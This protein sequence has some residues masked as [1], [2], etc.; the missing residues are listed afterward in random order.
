MH[1][2]HMPSTA[3]PCRLVRDS[4]RWV[5][6]CREQAVAIIVLDHGRVEVIHRAFFGHHRR[7]DLVLVVA[8]GVVVMMLL[9]I[10][11]PIIVLVLSLLR[12]RHHRGVPERIPR[13]SQ[14]RSC[15]HHTQTPQTTKRVRVPMSVRRSV[16]VRPKHPAIRGEREVDRGSLGVS[17]VR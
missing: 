14:C 10:A 12:L 8:M 9:F 17:V 3:R 1:P 2:L 16:S 4:H 11:V 15:A 7:V 6:V 13:S 5:Q